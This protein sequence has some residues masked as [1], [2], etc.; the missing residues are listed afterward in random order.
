MDTG[1]CADDAATVDAVA[2]VGV[3][4]MVGESRETVA[5]G[6]TGVDC[7]LGIRSNRPDIELRRVVHACHDDDRRI[8]DA[9]DLAADLLR[10]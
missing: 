10:R 5:T 3:Q 4:M 7:A 2:V 8:P 6:R 9:V 1:Q